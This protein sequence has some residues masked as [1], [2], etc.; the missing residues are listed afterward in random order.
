MSIGTTP[1]K[2]ARPPCLS[3]FFLYLA[4][5]VIVHLV[6]SARPQSPQF[7]IDLANREGN[8][9]G[10][11]KEGIFPVPLCRSAEAPLLDNLP[12]KGWPEW[13]AAREATVNRQGA[14]HSC[15]QPTSPR[16]SVRSS[17]PPTRRPIFC[18]SSA[19]LFAWCGMCDM[20]VP[21][22]TLA[23]EPCHSQVLLFLQLENAALLS[24]G[25]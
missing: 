3:I 8:T 19:P 22:H 1:Q 10:R 5:S 17:T 6:C 23:A 2:D 24:G 7:L 16:F 14:Y 15:A 18:P 20:V 11:T 25:F 21:R 13:W 12:K 9:Q 4:S